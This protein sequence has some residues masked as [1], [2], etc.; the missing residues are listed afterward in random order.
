MN[1]R[2]IRT[3]PNDLRFFANA[4]L[5]GYA[6]CSNGLGQSTCPYNLKSEKGKAWSAGW[7]KASRDKDNPNAEWT[8]DPNDKD[9]HPDCD[10]L[11]DAIHF[12]IH[13]DIAGRYVIYCASCEEN[14]ASVSKSEYDDPE[15]IKRISQRHITARHPEFD[16]QYPLHNIKEPDE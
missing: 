7:D 15:R 14:V 1:E 16:C 6:S 10:P 11:G 9:Y 3:K 13:E 4:W 12:E 5:K 2:G 8:D